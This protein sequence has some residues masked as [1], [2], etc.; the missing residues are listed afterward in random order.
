MD[1]LAALALVAVIEGLAMLVFA[2]SVP[3]LTAAAETIGPG[4]LRRVGLICVL[5]G[6]AAYLAIRGV[7]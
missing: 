1:L 4:G 7:L 2:R 6:A 3:D 5:G